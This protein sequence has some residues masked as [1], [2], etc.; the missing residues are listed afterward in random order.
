MWKL[1]LVYQ[2][3]LHSAIIYIICEAIQLNQQSINKSHKTKS[4]KKWMVNQ[5]QKFY[6]C[7][8]KAKQSVRN[9]RTKTPTT[10][11]R[12]H[13]SAS[14]QDEKEERRAG[15]RDL[16]SPSSTYRAAQPKQDTSR[17]KMHHLQRETGKERKTKQENKRWDESQVGLQL[18]F[19]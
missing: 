1:T 16:S 15:K 10:E 18:L 12:D 9:K 13:S 7:K 4:S 19:N 11:N 6:S 8:N 5:I 14:Q 3:L 2:K 17:S